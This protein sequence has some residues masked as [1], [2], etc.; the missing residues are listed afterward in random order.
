MSM[1]CLHFHSV[2]A[3]TDG[4]VSCE[5]EDMSSAERSS[6]LGDGGEGRL[7]VLELVGEMDS[8]VAR[9]AAESDSA[10][11]CDCEKDLVLE[12]RV[13]TLKREDN[14]EGMREGAADGGV[15]RLMYA[16]DSSRAANE[17]RRRETDMED[18]L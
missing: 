3:N 18:N 1:R 10:D 17:L 2:R 4:C 15:E 13:K 9:L 6:S 12:V 7:V 14:L 16:D 11:G 5:M 8:R